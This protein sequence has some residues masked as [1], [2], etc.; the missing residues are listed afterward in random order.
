M[1]S[2]SSPPHLHHLQLPPEAE[3]E[4]SHSPTN[5]LNEKGL[6]M[7]MQVQDIPLAPKFQTACPFMPH[8]YK[9]AELLVRGIGAYPSEKDPQTV[10]GQGYHIRKGTRASVWAA[11][12][13]LLFG[14][15][16]VQLAELS[17]QVTLVHLFLGTL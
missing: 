14:H 10:A 2:I 7:L 13:G 8:L 5:N 6:A 16:V 12:V 17:P 9:N 1:G 15:W 11:C 4:S 3:S